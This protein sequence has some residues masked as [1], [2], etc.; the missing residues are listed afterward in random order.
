MVKVVK[1]KNSQ[2]RRKKKV[3]LGEKKRKEFRQGP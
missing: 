1:S 3:V 2:G